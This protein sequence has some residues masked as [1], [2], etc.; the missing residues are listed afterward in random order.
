[1][2]RFMSMLCVSER[3]LGGQ[4]M[5]EYFEGMKRKSSFQETLQAMDSHAG[6]GIASKFSVI[7]DEE[8]ERDRAKR[9]PSGSGEEV[10]SQLALTEEF[11]RKWF[12]RESA[13]YMNKNAAWV[14]QNEKGRADWFVRQMMGVSSAKRDEYSLL[15]TSWKVSQSYLASYDIGKLNPFRAK[16]KISKNAMGVGDAVTLKKNVQIKV[17]KGLAGEVVKM[18]STQT[19]QVQFDEMFEKPVTLGMKYFTPSGAATTGEQQGETKDEPQ[20]KQQDTKQ[21]DTEPQ[22][23]EGNHGQTRA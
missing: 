7:A 5:A 20:N 12:I 22:K 19:L 6:T 17:P 1:M 10:E 16:N 23:N 3:A 13:K 9:Y 2:G 21:Q 14:I 15:A 4:D 11:W 8:Q 18:A